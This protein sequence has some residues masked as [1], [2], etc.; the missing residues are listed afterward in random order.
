MNNKALSIVRKARTGIEANI[1]IEA[2]S[3]AGFHPVVLASVSTGSHNSAE[4]TLH[5]EVPTTEISAATEFLKLHEN[6]TH[7]A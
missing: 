1:L 6:P 4:V 2:L 5:I 7:D 3:S